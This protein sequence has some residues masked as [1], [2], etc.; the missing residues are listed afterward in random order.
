MVVG[1]TGGIASGKST[2]SRMFRDDGVPVIC[3][4]ELAREAVKPGAP[5]LEEIR[6]VFGEDMIGA[7]GALDR[8]KM[9]Q[10]VFPDAAKRAALEGIIH[11]KVAEG[12]D[13]LIRELELAGH[14]TVIVDVPLLFEKGWDK[15]CDLVIVVFVP[16][17]VQEERLIK[18]DGLSREDARARLDAQT[19]IEEKKTLAD[20]VVDNTGPLEQT[21]GQVKTLV[22]ELRTLAGEAISRKGGEVESAGPDSGAKASCRQG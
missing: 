21:L 7:D 9:A 3:A 19:P 12:K 18:R 8:T 2:V 14:D 10:I 15:G 17:S 13:R 20:R 6:R 22:K 1:L 4:D 16:R 5:A 11:P